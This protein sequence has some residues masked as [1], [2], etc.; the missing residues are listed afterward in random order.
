MIDV[1]SLWEKWREQASRKLGLEERR[2]NLWWFGKADGDDGVRDMAKE[3][4]KNGVEVKW[5]SDRGIKEVLVFEKDVLRLTCG[6]ALQSERK[7]VFLW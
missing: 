5:L 6:Y 2:Y 4:C 3:L 7:A 1:C